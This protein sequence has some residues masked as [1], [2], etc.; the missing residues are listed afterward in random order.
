MELLKLIRIG[1]SV[2]MVI[3]K[4]LRRRMR[5]QAGDYV[6]LT[7]TQDGYRVTPY[8]PVLE[9]QLGVANYVAKRRKDVLR[10]LAD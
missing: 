1:N 4:E 6:Y 3:P 10:G 8:N 5:V 9:A 7:D 2:G